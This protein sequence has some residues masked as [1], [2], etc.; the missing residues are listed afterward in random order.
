VLAGPIFYELEHAGTLLRFF[1]EFIRD[2]PREF[3]G[4]P[5]FQV[6]PPLPFIPPHRHGETLCAAVVHWTGDLAQ[7]ERVIRRFRELA[8]VVAEH[9]GVLPYPALNGAF[10]ALFPKGIRSYWKGANVTT[11]TE[12]AVAAHLEHGPKVPEVSATMHLYPINGAVH[13]VGAADTAFPCRNATYAMVIV[14]A[15]MDPA[16]DESRI[17]WVRDYYQATAPHADAECYV[18]FMADDDR[19]RTR[20][21][22]GSAYP[23][24][25]E[26]KRRYDPE[27]VFHVNQNIQ[28]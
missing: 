21:N 23:R 12:E 1:D 2:A 16:S 24:L 28:P 10:D 6:A 4:F 22:Y 14:S 27:N 17:R 7:G 25:Q 11:L 18:N 15:W 8:P 9:V 20:E 19:G 3:G 13:E 5:A 26:V